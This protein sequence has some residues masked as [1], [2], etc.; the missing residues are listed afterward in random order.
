MSDPS[1][2]TARVARLFDALSPSY[3]GVGVDFFGPIAEGLLDAMP[4]SAGERWLDVGCGR[5]AVLL[6]AAG[7]LGVDGRAVGIDIS[8]AMAAEALRL[9]A[10]AGLGTVSVSVGD[11]AAPMVVGPFDAVASSLVLF[12]L[13]DPLAALR[14]WLPLLA[15]AGRLG[16]ATFGAVDARWRHVDEV[17]APYLPPGLSDARTTGQAGPFE[18]DHGM[19]RLVAEAGYAG[20]RTVTGTVAVRFTDAE[21]W[22]AFTWSTGQRAMWLA[23]PEGDRPGIRAEAERRLAS[24]AAADGSVTFDQA[25]RYTLAVRPA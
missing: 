8:P 9:S 5:G 14:A 18:T 21:R 1:E 20:V 19:E 23:I 2:Q 4:P 15:P 25:V 22:H 16:I 12:F 10:E 3:D 11:A 13:P 24:Y 17:F 7:A 6:R